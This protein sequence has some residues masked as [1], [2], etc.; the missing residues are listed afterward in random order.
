MDSSSSLKQEWGLTQAAFD[1]VLAYLDPERECAGQKYEEIRQKLM[2]FFRWR[3]CTLSAECTDITI[4]RV[5]R[6]L[7]EGAELQV[8]EPYLYFHGVA[9]N[10]LREYWRKSE[11]E[12]AT[13]DDSPTFQ[14]LADSPADREEQEWE[15]QA[16]EQRL[17]CMRE[18]V[19]AL[20]IESRTLIYQYHQGEKKKESRK[21]LA[22]AL[23]LPL[24]ALRLRVHRLRAGLEACVDQ[25]LKQSH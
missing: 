24:N 20:P 17:K 18:C 6:R 25:C 10:V 19:E 3:G 16:A 11:K 21:D 14:G 13:S 5:A 2:K 1:R 8:R 7:A 9:L 12:V 22:A 15:E 23:Q 4:D